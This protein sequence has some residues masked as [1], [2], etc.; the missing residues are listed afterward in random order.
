[1]SHIAVEKRVSSSTQSQALNA[2]VF[3]FRHVL[4]KDIE[5]EIS[6]VRSYKKRSLPVVLT[7]KEVNEGIQN[8]GY[9]SGYY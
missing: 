6:A 2:I 4:E 9:K 7:V 1:M 3:F 5:N 8:S